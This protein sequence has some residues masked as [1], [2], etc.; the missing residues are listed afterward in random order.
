MSKRG[1][2]VTSP[3][4]RERI[5]VWN[6]LKYLDDKGGFIPIGVEDVLEKN[7][8]QAHRIVMELVFGNASSRVYFRQRNQI[9]SLVHWVLLVKGNPDGIIVDYSYI[10]SSSPVSFGVLM[11]RFEEE[12]IH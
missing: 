3:D 9:A 2:L 7:K 5:I 12:L 11:D 6:M 1:V 10:D 4:R 8:N